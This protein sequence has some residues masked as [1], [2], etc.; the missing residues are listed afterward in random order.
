MPQT[1][2]IIVAILT[3]LTLLACLGLAVFALTIPHLGFFVVMVVL[4]LFIGYFSYADY[5]RFF[6]KKTTDEPKQ[7]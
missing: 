2:R 6:G 1:I 7:E 5:L 3:F 4:S